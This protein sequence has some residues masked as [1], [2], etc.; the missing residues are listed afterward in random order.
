MS[1]SSST[2]DN[3]GIGRLHPAA[4]KPWTAPHHFLISVHHSHQ[5]PQQEHVDGNAVPDAGALHFD[6]HSFAVRAQDSFVHLQQPAQAAVR[7]KQ[8]QAAM[9]LGLQHRVQSLQQQAQAGMQTEV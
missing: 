6:G 2:R 4:S 8:P 3:P 7:D 5:P 1:W 9:Q